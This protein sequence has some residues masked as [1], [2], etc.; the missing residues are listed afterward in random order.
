MIG[1]WLEI[2][3][4]PGNSFKQLLE[5]ACTTQHTEQ[6]S[7]REQLPQLQ[8]DSFTQGARTY[9]SNTKNGIPFLDFF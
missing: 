6:T 8:N 1:E 9:N 7:C 4:V 2:E 3:A 5:A